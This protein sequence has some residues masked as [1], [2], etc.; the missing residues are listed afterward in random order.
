MKYIV[1][2]GVWRVTT[3]AATCQKKHGTGGN[4][5]VQRRIHFIIQ[6]GLVIIIG[7]CDCGAGKLFVQTPGGLSGN[8]LKTKIGPG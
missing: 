6:C 3:A 2:G 1:I 4:L 5:F 8:V 7:E